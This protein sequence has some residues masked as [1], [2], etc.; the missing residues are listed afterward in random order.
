MMNK[1]CENK[2]LKPRNVKLE[3]YTVDD[4]LHR[5]TAIGRVGSVEDVILS[6]GCLLLMTWFNINLAGTGYLI[7]LIAAHVSGFDTER[8]L[9]EIAKRNCTDVDYVRGCIDAAIRCNGELCTSMSELLHEDI[10]EVSSIESALEMYGAAY[11]IY[12]NYSA[13]P[14]SFVRTEVAA[15]SEIRRIIENEQKRKA[16]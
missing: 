3:D 13:P 14:E 7:S 1:L 8:A 15:L 16:I 2:Y 10:T 11:V 4:Y 5:E 9:L 6:A 12:Y